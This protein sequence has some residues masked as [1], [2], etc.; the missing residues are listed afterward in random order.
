MFSPTLLNGLAQIV[1][2]FDE[3]PILKNVALPRI[4]NRVER[5]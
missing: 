1:L 4:S 3:A 5:E 2:L